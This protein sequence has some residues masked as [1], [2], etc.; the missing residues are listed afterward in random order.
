MWHLK[1]KQSLMRK[2]DIMGWGCLPPHLGRT[3]NKTQNNTSS[4]S[5]LTLEMEQIM[6]PLNGLLSAV[7]LIFSPSLSIIVVQVQLPPSPP[8]PTP[9]VLCFLS[10]LIIKIPWKV[11]EKCQLSNL[12]LDTLN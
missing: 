8:P 6:P 2:G 10:K 4:L 12:A 3:L 1:Q 5:F 7:F 11:F 9:E